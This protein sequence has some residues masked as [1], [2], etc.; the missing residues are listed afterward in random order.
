MLKCINSESARHG[1]RLVVL[2][3]RT[4]LLL[5]VATIQAQTKQADPIALQEG[6]EI[7]DVGLEGHA[8]PWTCDIDGD[9]KMDLLVGEEYEGRL[10]IY[11]HF[12]NDFDG[13]SLLN[14][15]TSGG[16]VPRHNGFSPCVVDLDQDGL[17]DILTPAWYG[18]VYW[19]RQT[20]IGKFDV[21]RPIVGKDGNAIVMEWTHGVTAADWNS[22]GKIDL[23]V[24][25]SHQGGQAGLVLLMNVSESTSVQFSAPVA[26][27]AGDK[28]LDV[29]AESPAPNAA[30]WDGDGLFDLLMGAGD[31]SVRFYRNQGTKEAPRFSGFEV[32]ISASDLESDS[33]IC[34]VDFDRDGKL[35]LLVGDHG[36]P[37]ER[38][39][40]AEE[41]ELKRDASQA[42]EDAMARW[43]RAFGFYRRMLKTHADPAV[44]DFAR[45]QVVEED[46]R[47]EA[48]YAKYREHSIVKQYRGRVMVFLRE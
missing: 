45:Q 37:F 42:H 11:H 41:E 9:G 7:L 16:R 29:P 33:K 23:I 3:Y 15:G 14:E 35:D 30:D 24:G 6:Y 8:S 32:L 40:G 46:Q 2:F 27:S 39:L 43:G 1:L 28:P 22:D 12:Q 21:G 26:V 36:K 5:G 47:Q 25:Q 20:Q 13:F 19:F 34:V 31:G 18:M 10:R 44:C 48:A 38:V 17:V 4:W